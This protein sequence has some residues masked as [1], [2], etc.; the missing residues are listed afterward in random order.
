M[1]YRHVAVCVLVTCTN[2]SL[3]TKT[4]H[5]LNIDV[6]PFML[7][8]HLRNESESRLATPLSFRCFEARNNGRV[9]SCLSQITRQPTSVSKQSGVSS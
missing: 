4:V 7:T 8:G 9:T 5:V 1:R 2:S 6:L 3:L